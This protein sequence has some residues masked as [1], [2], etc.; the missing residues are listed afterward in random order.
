MVQ[1]CSHAAYTGL[2][3][4]PYVLSDVYAIDIRKIVKDTSFSLSSRV[5]VELSTSPSIDSCE[6]PPVH[7]P[8]GLYS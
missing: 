4:H 8:S 3:Y 7:L 1:L 5:H 2:A 6:V